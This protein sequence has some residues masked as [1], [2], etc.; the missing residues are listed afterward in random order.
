M[1]SMSYSRK[2]IH[3]RCFQN[4]IENIR[5]AFCE[6]IEIKYMKKVM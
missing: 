2:Q 6:K 3:S 4:E 1:D 5:C